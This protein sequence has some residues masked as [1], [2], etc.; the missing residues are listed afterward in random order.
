MTA[1][2]VIDKAYEVAGVASEKTMQSTD[3]ARGKSQGGFESTKQKL[4]E[5][6]EAAKEVV[7]GQLKATSKL[8]SDVGAHVK[9]M[10]GSGNEEL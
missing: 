1:K 4:E 5:H 8:A 7:N 10:A 9:H 6:Y 3:A 2:A